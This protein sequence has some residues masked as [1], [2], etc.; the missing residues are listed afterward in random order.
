VQEDSV[1]L[2]V[3]EKQALDG[4]PKLACYLFILPGEVLDVRGDGPEEPTMDTGVIHGPLGISGVGRN[5]PINVAAKAEL[6]NQGLEGGRPLVEVWVL[7]LEDEGDMR[8]D[9]DRGVGGDDRAGRGRAQGAAGGR[10][11]GRLFF[12]RVEAESGRGGTA[13]QSRVRGWASRTV[14]GSRG[15]GGRTRAGAS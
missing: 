11:G 10:G 1:G 7:Q 13:E 12:H 3:G 4:D 9:D 14:E 15:I 8:A 6:P 5:S 2:L